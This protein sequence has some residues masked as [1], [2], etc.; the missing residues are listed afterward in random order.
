MEVYLIQQQNSNLYK[1][2]V[3][4]S[5]K[6]RLNE[7]QTANAETLILVGSFKTKHGF[8]LESFLHRKYADHNVQLEWFEL[9]TITVATF[10]VHCQQGEDM[11]DLLLEQ[12]TY[13]QDKKKGW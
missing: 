13:I 7:L 3:S 11:F 6:K 10:K 2:G 1:I 9:D 12:N 8:Q 4:K 5:P